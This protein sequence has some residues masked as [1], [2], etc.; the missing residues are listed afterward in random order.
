MLLLFEKEKF[1]LNRCMTW[2]NVGSFHTIALITFMLC[3]LFIYILFFSF[4]LFFSL[5]QYFSLSLFHFKIRLASNKTR[6][7]LIKMV[8]RQNVNFQMNLQRQNRIYLKYTGFFLLKQKICLPGLVCRFYSYVHV[9][10]NGSGY[11]A[12]D[13]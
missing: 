11:L 2:C 12:V 5:F 6:H 10:L 3:V 9:H 8:Q 1:N 7:L 4:S 13:R